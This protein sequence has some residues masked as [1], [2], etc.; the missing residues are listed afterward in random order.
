MGCL[1]M[2]SCGTNYSAINILLGLTEILDMLNLKLSCNIVVAQINKENILSF[3]LKS[4]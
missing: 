4:L 3:A 2:D 1:G